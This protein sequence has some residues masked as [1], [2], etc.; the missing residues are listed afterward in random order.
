MEVALQ[1][2]GVQAHRMDNSWRPD[3]LSPMAGL[4]PGPQSPES[5]ESDIMKHH[6]ILIFGGRGRLP[7]VGSTKL[8]K[9]V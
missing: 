6:L 1:L 8:T 5:E 2:T 4:S 3:C 7:Y 9:I